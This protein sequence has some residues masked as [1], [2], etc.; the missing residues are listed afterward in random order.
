MRSRY[1]AFALRNTPYLRRTWHPDTRPRELELDGRQQWTG[2]EIVDRA[3]GGLFDAEGTVEFR[4]HYTTGRRAGVQHERS[5][6]RRLDGRW[7]YVSAA[8]PAAPTGRAGR[9]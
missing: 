4:A 7:V 2:L 1:S 5:L 3:G 6:F 9:R 8:A